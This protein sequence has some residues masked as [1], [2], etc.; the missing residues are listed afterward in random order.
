MFPLLEFLQVQGVYP[1]REILAAKIEALA[2]TNMVDFAMDIHASLHGADAPCTG[3]WPPRRAAPHD[4]PPRPA[5]AAVRRAELVERRTEVVAKLK[6][7][8]VSAE[9]VVAFLTNPA[10]VKQLRNDKAYN[11]EMLK[12]EH[13]ARAQARAK[14]AQTLG[15]RPPSRQAPH[16]SARRLT[17][18]RGGARACRLGS[19]TS[20]PCT[21]TPRSSSRAA[22]TAAPPSF[23]ATTA[24]CAAARSAA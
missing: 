21:T 16:A 24:R 8:Q 23:C 22:T 15:H 4:A 3:A 1:E 5:D 13:Q 20:R 19:R 6:E 11:L 12:N 17:R 14:A 7:L 2:K 18:A 9:A 10:L